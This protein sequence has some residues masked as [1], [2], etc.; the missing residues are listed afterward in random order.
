MDSSDLQL[1][2]AI[3][4]LKE[5]IIFI[6]YRRISTI[7]NVRNKERTFQGITEL[8][9]FSSVMGGFPLLWDPV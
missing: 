9:Q 2:P 6:C 5:P 7:A 1:N 4:D 8:L 3:T